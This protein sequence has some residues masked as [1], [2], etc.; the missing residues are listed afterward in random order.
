MTLNETFAMRFADRPALLS[1]LRA[2]CVEACLRGLASHADLS[3]LLDAQTA[4]SAQMNSDDDYWPDQ[5]DWMAAYR[6]YIVKDGV[7]QI[8]VKGVLLHDFGYQLGSWATGYNYIQKAM[9]RGLADFSVKG[10]ALVIDSPGGMVAG[11]FEL[12]DKLAAA[13]KEK[14]MKAYAFE[15]A[16]SAAFAIACAPGKGNLIISR[17]G[18]C[19]SVGVV[20]SHLDVSGA[21]EQMGYKITF[22]HAGKHK[23]D[24]NAYEALK[25]EVKA[26]IQA[27]IDEMYDIFVAS[28]AKNREMAEKDVRATEAL[29]Y[30]A[31]EAIEVGFA[32]KIGSL[33]V[34]L[35][36]FS[37]ALKPDAGDTFM[38]QA[39]QA[40]AAATNEQL[41]AARA[42]GKAE[43]I[44]EGTK[45]GATAERARI[46]AVLA[47]PAAAK[48]Q[49]A[50]MKFATKTNLS[51]EEITELLEDSAEDAPAAAAASPKGVAF[52]K[53][54]DESG[55]PNPGVD[56]EQEDEP[57]AKKILRS[58]GKLR[59][60]GKKK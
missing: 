22:I 46:S 35:A 9:E 27:Q 52:A 10:I 17:T 28:V 2:N 6:P 19:G 49:K 34:E 41:A 37:A 42:E 36:E 18:G 11:C 44:A 47:L 51:V 45:A 13:S 14:P 12:V 58:A 25:P 50:A 20:T 4:S 3:K 60:D 54:M 29:C 57:T 23:V 24:G 21:M 7:L 59:R 40:A 30:S 26:R 32:D 55:N 31:S 15:D 5:D 39:T 43:G 48:K 33:D 16:Y 1:P 53:A 56:G 38:S 8:P